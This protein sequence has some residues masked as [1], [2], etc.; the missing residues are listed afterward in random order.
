MGYLTGPRWLKKCP[1]NPAKILQLP[2]KG[3]LRIGADADITV[4]DPAVSW[5]V[6]EKTLHSKSKNS[7]Y[8]GWTLEGQAVVVIV[9]GCFK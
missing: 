9:G 7:P 6:S 1:P 4:I 5:T 3:T 2:N 8:L